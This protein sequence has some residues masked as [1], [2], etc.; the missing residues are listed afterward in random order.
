MGR[1]AKKKVDIPTTYTA[2][3]VRPEYAALAVL[4]DL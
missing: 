1:L 2:Y 3:N 4:S